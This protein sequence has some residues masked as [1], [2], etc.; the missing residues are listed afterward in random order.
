MPFYQFACLD[1]EKEYEEMCSYDENNEYPDVVCPHCGSK[2]KQK[3]V[4]CPSFNFSNPVGTDRW[5]N[6]ATGHDY[7]FKY[8]IPNVK[9]QRENAEEKSHMGT[10]V[11][12]EID[13]ISSGKHFGEVK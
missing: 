4:S 8:N 13:D 1:C 11:Y 5:T 7:R 9:K 3:L 10:D 6:N 12:R 2:K